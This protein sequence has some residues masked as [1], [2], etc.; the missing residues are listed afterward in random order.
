[1]ENDWHT[2]DS[3]YEDPPQKKAA[4]FS[5]GCY[6]ESES[7]LLLVCTQIVPIKIS[8]RQHHHRQGK[9]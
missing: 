2:Q 1:M 3:Y 4:P 7:R 9:E 8:A 6:H 5:R